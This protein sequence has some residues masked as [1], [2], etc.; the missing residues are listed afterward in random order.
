MGDKWMDDVLCGNNDRNIRLEKWL[1]EYGSPMLRICILC[2]MDVGLAEKA[3]RHIF[4]KAYRHM[5][6]FLE[7]G[8]DG[9][10]VFLMRFALRA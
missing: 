3:M 7:K 8:Q 2:L 4:L 5:D 10:K 6:R 1:D 9:E